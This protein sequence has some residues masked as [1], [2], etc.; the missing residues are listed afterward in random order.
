VSANGAA[1]RITGGRRSSEVVEEMGASLLAYVRK[2]PGQRGED[3]AEEL[4]SDSK[5]IRLPMKK[6][7]A[8]G[9]VR[10]KGERRGMR[11][12]PA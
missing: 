9:Q 3:I 6:L 1:S 4:G 11:Y 7:I 2:N 12:Y 10:T 8:E 5:T